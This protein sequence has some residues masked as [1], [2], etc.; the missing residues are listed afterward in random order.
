MQFKCIRRIVDKLNEFSKALNCLK[1][2]DFSAGAVTKKGAKSARNFLGEK[3]KSLQKVSCTKI[4]Q[5]K[6][7]KNKNRVNFKSG[8]REH[9]ADKA[10]D[11][12]KKALESH[13][14]Q[15]EDHRKKLK[16]FK[17]TPEKYDNE[18]R[19]KNAPS[20]E[21]RQK[22]ISERIDVLEKAIAR[23]EWIAKVIKVF[24]AE[25]IGN[26]NKN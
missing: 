25:G 21:I 23:H 9:Y 6:E 2:P 24:I 5:L 8:T 18:G 7:I 15:A 12:Q 19:Q 16:E 3:K 4:K 22:V 26:G 10:C 17:K 13:E 11:E 14:W 20:E 1:S